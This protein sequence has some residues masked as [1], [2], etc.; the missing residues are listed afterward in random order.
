[1][2]T[3]RPHV[4]QGPVLRQCFPE[5]AS[6]EL[7]E[8]ER[9][10]L[11]LGSKA[12]L[13]FFS[14]LN[15]GLVSGCGGHATAR[16]LLPQALSRYSWDA[17]HTLHKVSLSPDRHRSPQPVSPALPPPPPARSP[18]ALHHPSVQPVLPSPTSGPR[19]SSD[20][21]CCKWYST[22]VSSRLS[23]KDPPGFSTSDLTLASQQPCSALADLPP[24]VPSPPCPPHF[25]G[26]G[27]ALGLCPLWSFNVR[28]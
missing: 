1:M 19:S 4:H 3:E 25:S 13:G 5:R 18:R 23:P 14:S 12:R 11:S 22:A 16:D 24:R 27:Q 15:T 8:A 21:V 6:A 9:V 28:T 20:L 2:R 17:A 7:P 26:A 10:G